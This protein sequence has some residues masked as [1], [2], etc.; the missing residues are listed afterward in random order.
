MDGD[1]A[2]EPE[3]DNF[4]LVLPLPYRVAI[5]LVLGMSI[6]FVASEVLLTNLRRLG[7]GLESTLPFASQNCI[8]PEDRCA[9]HHN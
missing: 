9:G 7:L 6:Y 5:V 8:H 1:P 3:L 4:S 2:I